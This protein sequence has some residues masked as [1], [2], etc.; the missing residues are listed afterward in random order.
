[1]PPEYY[2]GIS[3]AVIL[4]VLLGSLIRGRRTVQSDKNSDTYQLA[5]Q[6]SRIADAL[7]KLVVH[8]GSSPLPVKQ[9]PAPVEK[10]SEQKAPEPSQTEVVVKSDESTKQHVV[11]S[12]F[13]R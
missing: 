9:P 2:L 4:L 5:H 12:M 3:V 13:G 7:E 1:M 10:P 8:L 11:L 6:L